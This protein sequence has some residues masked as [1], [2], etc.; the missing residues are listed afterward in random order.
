[1][2]LIKRFVASGAH[3]ASYP[4]GTWGSFPLGK[5]AGVWSWPLTS[6]YCRGQECVELYPHS[7]NTPSW[8]G[9]Q[10]KKW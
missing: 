5:E 2:V 9:A 8:C 3:P 1:V 6:I 10:L 4:T 7:F